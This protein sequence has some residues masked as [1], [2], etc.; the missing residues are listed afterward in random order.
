MDR[1]D[2]VDPGGGAGGSSG[3][4]EV[5]APREDAMELAYE[6]EGGALLGRAH[7]LPLSRSDV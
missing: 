1:L 7:R 5:L 2:A 6:L 3:A 4:L